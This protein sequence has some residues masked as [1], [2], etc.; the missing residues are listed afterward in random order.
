MAL[1]LVAMCVD[2]MRY[3]FELRGIMT[4]LL[5]ITNITTVLPGIA[6]LE[7]THAL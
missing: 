3:Y 5:G 6:V 2:F 7:T 4:K 1:P